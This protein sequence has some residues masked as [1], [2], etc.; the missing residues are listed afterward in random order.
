MRRNISYLNILALW[1]LLAILLL[2]ACS[3]A[4]LPASPEA[5]AYSW[6]QAYTGGGGYITGIVQDASNPQ[7]VYA[8]CDVAGVFKSLDGGESWQV[9]NSGLDKWYHHYVR[10]LTIHPAKGE[11]VFR[12]SGDMRNDTLFGSIHKSVDGGRN[13]YEVSNEMGFFGNGHTRMFGELIAA[14]PHAPNRILAAGHTNGIWLSEDEGESWQFKEAREETFITVAIN[15]YHPNYYYAATLSGKLWA[16][17][18]GGDSWQLI[19]EQLNPGM[20]DLYKE[21]AGFTELAFDQQNPALVYAARIKGGIAKSLD[22]GK[23]FTPIMKGLPQGFRYNTLTADPNNTAVLYTA[24]D[25]RPNHPL[26]NIPIYKSDN[27]GESWTLINAHTADNMA[28]YPSYIKT[29]PHA[30]WAISKVRVDRQNSQKLL[31]ANWYGVSTSENGGM[32][33]DAHQFRG[34]ET[35]CL[36]NIKITTDRVY[37][38]VADHSPMMSQDGG[39]TYKSLPRSLYSGSTALVQSVFDTS[40][41][42]FGTWERPYGHAGIFAEKGDHAQLLQQWEEPAF[43]QALREDPFTAGLFYAYIDGEYPEKGGLYQSSD[44]G[45]SWTRLPLQLPDYIRHLPH[46]KTFIEEELLNIVVDQR[47]NVC[48]SDKLLSID[49]HQQGTIYFGEWTEGVFRSRDGGQSWTNISQGLPFKKHKASVLAV[50]QNDPK[51]PGHLY[52]GF[53]REGLWRS[54]NGGDSWEKV[55]PLEDAIYNVNSMHIGG[56]SGHELYIA[57]ENLY[58]SPSPVSLKKSADGGRNWQELYDPAMGALRIKG[59]D[60]DRKTGRIVL[61]SSGNGAFYIE[62]ARQVKTATLE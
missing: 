62:P 31:F 10:S 32:D 41:V 11:V 30:G 43:I 29:L 4:E 26:S 2:Q 16:S 44:W 6:H 38:T 25:T 39:K 35:N 60:V 23:S 14:D 27:A 54:T 8:R 20:K 9:M 46:E 21:S 45:R 34:L 59:I 48:G 19:Y 51:Q 50:L 61:A 56:V 7:L 36:E 37:Y 22:G 52:A 49:P 13:W 1:P 53:I 17:T 40:L 12:C 28:N 18:D 15:P 24:P 47:K 57:G 3:S 55:Y 33:W 58:W 5:E 42:L